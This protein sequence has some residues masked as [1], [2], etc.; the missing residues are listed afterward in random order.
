MDAL[1]PGVAS[2]ATSLPGNTLKGRLRQYF[3]HGTG[4]GVGLDIHESPGIGPLSKDV[5]RDGM[6]VTVEPGYTYQAG[7][8]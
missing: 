5:L 6:V 3:G 8:A 7:A 1:K 4:H 2:A